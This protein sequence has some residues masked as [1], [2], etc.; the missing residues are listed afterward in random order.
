MKGLSSLQN[1]MRLCLDALQVTLE[2]FVRS[3]RA[4]LL[5]PCAL[6]TLCQIAT[7]PV[8]FASLASFSARDSLS[9]LTSLLRTVYPA[10]LRYP[11]LSGHFPSQPKWHRMMSKIRQMSVPRCWLIPTTMMQVLPRQKAMS[12]ASKPWYYRQPGSSCSSY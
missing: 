3:C 12:G 6:S 5:L 9:F 8:S 7:C 11:V 10:V 4:Q 2:S 1:C